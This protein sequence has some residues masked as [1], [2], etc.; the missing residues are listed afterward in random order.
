MVNADPPGNSRGN[1]PGKWQDEARRLSGESDSVTREMKSRL[2]KRSGLEKELLK[3]W[4]TSD[5]FLALEVITALD[6]KSLISFLNENAFKDPDGYTLL[7]LNTFLD[8]NNQASWLRHQL[9]IYNERCTKLTPQIHFIILDFMG[10]T[11]Q[12]ISKPCLSWISN[13]LEE[14][15][16]DL[17]IYNQRLGY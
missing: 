5:R 11:H 6:L 15:K 3:A 16:Q 2:K 13:N 1:W 7:T 10:R 8:K 17:Q 14:L 12:K 4:E 9:E